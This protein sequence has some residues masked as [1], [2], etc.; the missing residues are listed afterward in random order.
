MI[1]IIIIVMMVINFVVAVAILALCWN[2]T[3]RSNFSLARKVVGDLWVAL[4]S[5]NHVC[6]IKERLTTLW[7]EAGAASSSAVQVSRP[8]KNLE[9]TSPGMRREGSGVAGPAACLR[10]QRLCEARGSGGLA[11][12]G[13]SLWE[14]RSARTTVRW[15][16]SHKPSLQFKRDSFQT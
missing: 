7:R 12:K 13:L 16:W 5:K 9:Y 3:D 6:F 2:F 1:C 8:S 11:Y 14:A 4:D 10:E 15:W